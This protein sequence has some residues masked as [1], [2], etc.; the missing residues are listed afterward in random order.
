MPTYANRHGQLGQCNSFCVHC[1][2]ARKWLSL[3][4]Q[5][6]MIYSNVLEI[7][8]NDGSDFKRSLLVIES[9][10]LR[11]GKLPALNNFFK[12]HAFAEAKAS[13]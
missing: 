4:R 9:C 3:M 5:A 7:V 10:R 11:Y 6:I 2:F 1:K 13:K 8:T 12:K